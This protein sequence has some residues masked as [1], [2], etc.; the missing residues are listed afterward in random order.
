[1]TN[2]F[3]VI[4]AVDLRDGHCVQL[5]GGDYAD[6]RVRLP[7]PVEQAKK[8]VDMGAPMLHVV[9]LDRATGN[10]TNESV[11]RAILDAVS[12]PVQVGG[13]IRST[14]DVKKM[15]GAGA[16]RVVVGTKAIAD[17]E[18]LAE[19]SKAYPDRIVVAVD[20][21]EGE[22]L[23][24]GWKKGSGMPL[25]A[26]AHEIDKYPTAGLLY[27]DVG[28]EGQLTGANLERVKA[29]TPG[30]T[31]PV[32]ASG[33]IATMDDLDGLHAAGAAGAV[34]GMAAYIGKIDMAKAFQRTW[35]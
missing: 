11:V 12:V 23:V 9:D 28:R 2:S 18:W 1:M 14:D 27:T 5:V 19:T 6:E 17:R 15:L 4:P 22:I 13:G 24:D 21:R 26:Y 30:L 29:L 25:L 7:D 10:G 33:G 31:R 20:A 3:Q 8:W 35:E 16:A 32:I 34:V